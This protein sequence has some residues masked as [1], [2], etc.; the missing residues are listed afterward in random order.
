MPASDSESRKNVYFHITSISTYIFLTC[1][2]ATLSRIVILSGGLASL[3]SLMHQ[4]HV[5][6]KAAVIFMLSSQ[7][8]MGSLGEISSHYRE[9]EWVAVNRR[10]QLLKKREVLSFFS[11]S[12][13]WWRINLCLGWGIIAKETQETRVQTPLP[14][15]RFL[16]SWF[17][18]P[19]LNWSIVNLQCCV[20]FWY[21]EKWFSYVCVCVC[22]CV[23]VCVCVCVLVTQ[24]CPTLCD[25]MDSSSPGS[26]VHG[27]LQTRTLEWAAIPFSRGFFQPRDQ[28]QVFHI[29]GRFFTIWATREAYIYS[30]S[31]SFP[32]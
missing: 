18:F 25:P 9:L 28:F 29:A 14:L 16:G 5:A 19:F 20:S 7:N 4:G 6:S 2:C 11:L 22:V 27:V 13:L 3:Q 32:L 10:A 17:F 21:T 30:F 26:S 23:S 8:A 12:F 24:W 15:Q 1:H 31:G